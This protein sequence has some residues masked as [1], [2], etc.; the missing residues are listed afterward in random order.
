MVAYQ[1]HAAVAGHG[2]EQLRLMSVVDGK[3]DVVAERTSLG[4]IA[5]SPDGSSL[6]FMESPSS[7]LVAYDVGKHRRWLMAEGVSRLP[8]GVA[9]TGQGIFYLVDG[10]LR[11]SLADGSSHATVLELGD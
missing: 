10:E 11:V 1:T 5:W 6:A 3:E 8:Q 4:Q 2:D 7:N 9:W